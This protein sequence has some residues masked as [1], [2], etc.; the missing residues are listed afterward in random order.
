VTASTDYVLGTADPEIDR[1]RL[2]HCILRHAMLSAFGRA[3]ISRDASVIDVGCGPGY[4]THDLAE[5]VGPQGHVLAIDRSSRFLDVLR[6]Q[7]EQQRLTN[8]TVLESDLMSAHALEQQYDFA[9]C[10]WVACFVESVDTLTNWLWAS[11]RPGGRAV[12]Y[13]YSDYASWRYAPPRPHL[14]SFVQEVMKSWR[15]AGGEPDVVPRLIP[16]LQRAGFSV[17]SRVPQV[18]SVTPKDL[19]WHWPNSFVATNVHRLLELGRVSQAWATN[20]LQELDAVQ[21]DSS[22]V[23]ITPLVIEIIA[24][25]A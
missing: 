19:M 9:W 25:R 3:G 16:A 2:Q 7:L 15:A 13:E 18:F 24:E 20:V 10:R 6:H 4:A 22:S 11:L 1:L 12:F 14:D 23:M 8:V 17:R 5:I 21:A